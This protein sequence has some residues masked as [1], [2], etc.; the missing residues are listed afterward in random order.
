MKMEITNMIKKLHVIKACNG[1]LTIEN[2]RPD[3]YNENK[4][5][6]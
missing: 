1:K 3:G 5:E 2:I 4:K 6:N